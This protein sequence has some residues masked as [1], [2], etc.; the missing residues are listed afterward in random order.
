M[1]A[2]TTIPSHIG[3]VSLKGNILSIVTY[4]QDPLIV[5]IVQ[6][7][8]VSQLHTFLEPHYLAHYWP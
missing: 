1:A 3:N 6:V 4:V 7:I 8:D 5:V 2:A